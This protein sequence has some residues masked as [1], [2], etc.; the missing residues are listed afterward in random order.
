MSHRK[1]GYR[2]EAGILPL[3][4]K[5]FLPHRIL[6]YLSPHMQVYHVTL[7]V[8]FPLESFLLLVRLN[9]CLME[10]SEK[11]AQML[12]KA[13]YQLEGTSILAAEYLAV[14]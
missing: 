13:R 2:V 4:P 1:V 12:C 8:C 14:F 5:P 10:K 9:Q 7:T 6:C 3:I 11:C